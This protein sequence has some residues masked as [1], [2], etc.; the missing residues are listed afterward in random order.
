MD[1]A[2]LYVAMAAGFNHYSGRVVSYLVAATFTWAMN[3]RFTFRVQ[4]GHS[5]WREWLRFLAANSAGGMLNYAVYALL[6]MAS[7]MV[8]KLPVIGVAAGSVAGLA[9]NFCLSKRL[10]FRCR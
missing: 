10:V 2:T 7:A 8:A 9:L 3:R 4:R 5:R 6:V 1:A